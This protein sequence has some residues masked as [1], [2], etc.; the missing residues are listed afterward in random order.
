MRCLARL[1]RLG[2]CLALA[3]A[4][5]ASPAAAAE[6]VE[7]LRAE[8]EDIFSDPRLREG[9]W[10]VEVVALA[11]GETVYEKN[12]HKLQTPASNM[13]ILTA[14]AALLRLGPDYRFRTHLAAD[15]PVVDGRLEGNLIVTGFG[16][17]SSSS[18][19]PP[20]DPFHPF[21]LWAA[22][23]RGM[24]IRAIEGNLVPGGAPLPAPAHGSGWAW[25]DLK[26]GYAAG[27]SALQFNENLVT[28]RVSPG[29]AVGSPPSLSVEPYFGY[30]AVFTEMVTGARSARARME[31]AD[32][33]TGDA[34]TVR[35]TVPLG[36]PPLERTASVKRPVR[37]YLSALRHALGRE[38][39]DVSR[40]RVGEEGSGGAP[41]RTLWTH[42]SPPLSE[43]L[44]PILKQSLNLP[45]ETLLRAL[46]MEIGGEGSAARGIAVVEETLAAAGIPSTDYAYA[47]G[48]GLSRMNL[49]SPRTLVRVLGHM[50]RHPRFRLFY[51]AL[52][53]AGV[54]GTLETRMRGTA[55]ENNVRAKTGTL[56][57]VSA[58]S[59]YVRSA[60]GELFAF[61]MIAGNFLAPAQTA[62]EI[63]DRALLRLARF[64]RGP[65]PG[66]GAASGQGRVR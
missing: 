44:P 51:D 23:L 52:A 13:K 38:G 62:E 50:H 33:G 42:H 5:L 61:S 54:D 6:G 40:C 66:A 48:S 27:V 22:R 21:R 59:G 24:G 28:I 15:G 53:V 18:R 14:A 65:G 25:D 12:A 17:P 11:R 45:S 55:A 2:S 39:I 35:G 30:P 57:R 9:Q 1:S 49:A 58:L 7:G 4:L 56:S 16:D 3:A 36:G 46:G 47:D 19:I 60:D 34:I 29:P 20:G 32:G 64:R 26:E 63:Q 8:L 43:L 37:Y 41:A 31:I 10:G